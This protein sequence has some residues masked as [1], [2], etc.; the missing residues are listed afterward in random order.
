[1]SAFFQKSYVFTRGWRRDE[2]RFLLVNAVDLEGE[3]LY[4]CKT[5]TKEQR[6]VDL[7]KQDCLI[8]NEQLILL[9][10][11][12]LYHPNGYLFSSLKGNLLG[13]NKVLE[14]IKRACR[15]LGI[16][17]NITNH[18]FRHYVVTSIGARTSNIE[19]IKAITGHKDTRT[20]LDHYMHPQK[21]MVNKA[22]EIT[23][24]DVDY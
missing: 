10:N 12:K 16:R 9:R 4:V 17:K 15:E 14:N 2:L 21:E 11:L 23:K 20:I 6:I 5:K 24:L 13:K 7:S 1:M 8:L 22:L 18:S 19:V 3:K